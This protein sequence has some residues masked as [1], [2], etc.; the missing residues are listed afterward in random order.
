MKSS[1][2]SGKL[3]KHG[4]LDTYLGQLSELLEAAVEACKLST[5]NEV[6]SFRE[7]SSSLSKEH[8]RVF[9]VGLD[10]LTSER[11]SN[12]ISKLRESNS[13][14]VVI[15]LQSTNRCGFIKALSIEDIN[16]GFDASRFPEGIAV[17]IADNCVDKLILDFDLQN[18]EV[19]TVGR[20][21]PQIAY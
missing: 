11:F 9:E 17:F 1:D 19:E 7:R 12:Y 4:E 21:W 6:A 15:W 3:Q 10:E 8:R 5:L 20:H 13:S 18:V 2:L 14:P 16:Y